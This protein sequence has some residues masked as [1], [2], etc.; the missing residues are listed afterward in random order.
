MIN[1]LCYSEESRSGLRWAVDRYGGKH[2]KVKVVSA[3]DSAG[4]VDSNG[5][6]MVTVNG[7]QM[8]ASRIIWELI[9]GEKLSRYEEIDHIDGNVKNNLFKNLRKVTHAINC[10]NRR[11]RVDNKSGYSGISIQDSGNGRFYAVGQYNL[12]GKL[13]RKR[14][15]IKKYGEDEAVRHATEWRR[16]NNVLMLLEGY[17]ERHGA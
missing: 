6:Y 17:T 12:A 15:S 3:G 7:K 13:I 2:Y 1:L 10:R 5:Y 8:I 11:K 14:W 16:S 9:T 4:W